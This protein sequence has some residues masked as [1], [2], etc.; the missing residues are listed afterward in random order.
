M[1][2]KCRKITGLNSGMNSSTLVVMT[3]LQDFAAVYLSGAAIAG[4]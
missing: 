1:T 2:D 3:S 4:L